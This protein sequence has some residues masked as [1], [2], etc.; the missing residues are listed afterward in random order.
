M[1]SRIRP[2][3]KRVTADEAIGKLKNGSRVF[4]GSGC[5]E[6]QHLIHT[7]VANRQLQDIMIFQMLSHTFERYLRD[8]D[9]LSRFALKLFFVTVSMR[10]A[11]FEGKIDYI[12]VYLSEIPRLFRNRQITLDAA[13]IQISPPDRFGLASLGVSVDVTREAV[14]S[15]RLVIAQ[16]NPKMPRT[17]GDGFIHVDD[18]DYLV[19]HDEAILTL[20]EEAVDQG[21]ARRIARYLSELIDNG[22]TLQ[23]GYGQMPFAVLKY[24][25]DKSDLG[26]H[27]HMMADAFVPLFEKGV[28]TNK[29]KNFLTDRAVSTFCMGSR[30]TYDYIDDNASFYFG[31]SDFV[32]N[33]RIIGQNDNFISI[34]SAL[35]VDLTGQVCS[36]SLGRQ[37]F[38]NTGDQ[39]NFIRGASLS[40]GGLSIIALPATA[41]EGSSRIVA[42]LSAGAGLA[43]L[44]ADVNFVVTEYGIAQL[45]GKS[46]HQRVIELAQIA[47][48]DYRADLIKA[49]K[50]HHYIFADQLPPPAKDL[51]F[52][53]AYKSRKT[54]KNGKTMSVRPLL[55]SDEIAYRNFLYSLE[56]KTIYYRF[57]DKIDVFTRQMA[58][59]HWANLDYRKNLSLAGVVHNK[60][61]NEIMAMGTYAEV[62]ADHAEVAFMVRE[63]FQGLGIASYILEELEKIARRNGYRFFSATILAEN[64]AMLHVF[65]KRYPQARVASL[66]GEVEIKMIF[67]A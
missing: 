46:I 53:E 28:I 31:T 20:P 5:G 18:I 25:A 11:A 23:I 13:L 2:A 16:I 24:L 34:T 64:A 60:G 15:A 55:P 59:D 12:P 14:R 10:Q 8:P 58:Q 40:K 22:S 44:R 51:M 65:K 67:P 45:K 66:G 42:T 36:D 7:M 6:P 21:T 39:S 56:E 38:S 33:P 30:T 49:A 50:G 17:H 32:N 35:E 52:I 63:D 48:P 3:T 54:L 43:T 41:K 19:P 37:F 27:T 4:I 9:F 47:H 57:F 62:D 29:K 26:V 1:S 61:D